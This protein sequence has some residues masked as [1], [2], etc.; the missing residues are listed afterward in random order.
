LFRQLVG[1]QDHVEA[2]HAGRY[3]DGIGAGL[4]KLLQETVTSMSRSDRLSAAFGV[5]SARSIAISLPTNPVIR[6]TA[7]TFGFNPGMDPC[8]LILPVSS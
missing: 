3:D 5:R 7:G 4:R 2:L 8:G 6:V 1:R